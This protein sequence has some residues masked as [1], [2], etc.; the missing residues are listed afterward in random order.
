V[1]ASDRVV[2]SGAVEGLVDETVLRALIRHVGAVPG[3]FYGRHGKEYLRKNWG[4]YN[5]AARSAPWVVLVDLDQDAGCVPPFRATWVPNPAPLMCF[6]VAVREIEAWL[7]SDRERLAHF[8]GIPPGMIPRHAE[9]LSDPK[10][11]MVDLARHSRRGDIRREMVPHHGSG[12]VVGPAYNSRLTEF[13]RNRRGGWRPEVAAQSSE[14]LRR[15]VRCLGRL[16]REARLN[17]QTPHP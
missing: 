6:R 17:P 7:L 9:S 11:T 10:R 15:C 3:P 5:Q 12:R 1:S 8:L 13:V 16:V 2:I 4:G 14:S